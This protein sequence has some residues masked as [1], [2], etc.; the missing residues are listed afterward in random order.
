MFGLISFL[1]V[2]AIAGWL[3][4]Y[5]LKGKGFGFLVNMLIGIVGAF[6]GGFVFKMVGLSA[7]GFI[8]SVITATVGAVI[9]LFLSGTLKKK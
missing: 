4:G 5:I 9:L 3:A 6:I 7:G 2:G 1:V 8:G